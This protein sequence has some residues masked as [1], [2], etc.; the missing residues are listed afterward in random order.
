MICQDKTVQ[1]PLFPCFVFEKGTEW[2]HVLWMAFPRRMVLITKRRCDVV[3]ETLSKNPMRHHQELFVYFSLAHQSV[4]CL[5]FC[6]L[7][8]VSDCSTQKLARQLMS[9]WWL[10]IT[11]IQFTEDLI[12]IV[13]SLE[14][15]QRYQQPPQRHQ[16][17]RQF[18][19]RTIGDFHQ[20]TKYEATN[21]L[22]RQ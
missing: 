5:V 19:G 4:C 13:V 2:Q 6:S 7:V 22:V 15:N 8:E 16:L 3:S 9:L 18:L 10:L 12:D 11:L 17:S 14:L 20:G 1:G 21:T